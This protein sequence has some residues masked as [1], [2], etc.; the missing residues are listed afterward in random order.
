MIGMTP[1]IVTGADGSVNTNI[2]GKFQEAIKADF[3]FVFVHI[4][5]TDTLAEDGD[6]R[7][8][9][10]FLEKIDKEMTAFND[11]NG[12]LIVTSDHSTSSLS[13][14]H[15]LIKIPFLVWGRGEDQAN[16]FSEKQCSKGSLGIINQIDFIKE[17][18]LFN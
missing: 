16:R 18:N 9:A 14:K 7:G 2:K 4:K 15:C 13:K 6:Y 3:D 10:K 12:T 17:I 8:K 5:A 11:F 1:L